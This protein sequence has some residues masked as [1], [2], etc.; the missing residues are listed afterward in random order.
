MNKWSQSQLA[1]KVGYSDKGMISRIEH[2]KIDLQQ[3]Q[4]LKFAKVFKIDPRT[5]MGWDDKAI[6]TVEHIES[7]IMNS[8]SSPTIQNRINDKLSQLNKEGLKMADSYMDFLLSQEPYIKTSSE[9][10]SGE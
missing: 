7:A 9:M 10:V 3:S 8:K 5:L 1:E 4:I 6:K 2:G